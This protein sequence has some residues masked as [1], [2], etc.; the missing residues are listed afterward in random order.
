[1]PRVLHFILFYLDFFRFLFGKSS[2]QGAMT[3]LHMALS[4]ESAVLDSSGSYWS[5]CR[6]VLLIRF[7]DISR[8]LNNLNFLKFKH[9]HGKQQ[10]RQKKLILCVIPNRHFSIGMRLNNF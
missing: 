10:F 8:P 1:M 5:D 4:N 9:P 7:Y 2:R 6:Q 3:T